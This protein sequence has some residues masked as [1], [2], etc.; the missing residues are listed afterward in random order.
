[1]QMSMTVIPDSYAGDNFNNKIKLL[2]RSSGI[3]SYFIP[4]ILNRPIVNGCWSMAWQEQINDIPIERWKRNN[5]RLVLHAQD[6]CHYWNNT[7]C[8]EMLAIED[9]LT[10]EQQ[11]K[12]IVLHWDHALGNTYTGRLNCVE[13]PSHSYE[14]VH[15]LKERYRE[16]KDVH[17]KDIKYNYLCL[18]GWL[19]E[20]RVKIYDILGNE[21]LGFTSHIV[22]NPAPMH[23]YSNYDFNNVNNFIRL[24]PLY[25]QSKT[26]IV[27]ETIYADHPGII[28]E[29]TLLAIA[30]KHPFMCIGHLGIHKEIA[31]R[32]F[33]IY[34]D[35]FDLSY[36]S[37][38]IEERLQQAFKLNWDKITNSNWDVDH[39]QEKAE[40]NFDFL[41]SDYTKTIEQ[42]A[43][44]QLVEIMKKS[45]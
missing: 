5:F 28:T 10:F 20:H 34:D 17:S 29:K 16:W 11:Q 2:L 31:Q 40:R 32:G 45:Y 35:V 18:N 44:R 22:Q 15:S 36:D 27:S 21:P 37:L 33:E 26:S 30:A 12:T 3:D 42:R 24:M 14:L 41:M 39:T 1:M 6:F 13:F 43:Q 4:S 25:Q 19:R 23:P 8:V 7:S 38:P 9:L